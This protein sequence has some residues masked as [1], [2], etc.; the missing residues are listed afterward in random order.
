MLRVFLSVCFFM[1]FTL[2]A[3]AQDESECIPYLDGQYRNMESGASQCGLSA[4]DMATFP[5]QNDDEYD[6][7]GGLDVSSQLEAFQACA[8][9]YTCAARF[10]ECAIKNKKSG[11][12]CRQAMNSCTSANPIPK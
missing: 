6:C 4:S 11:M 12:G 7:G 5:G 9:V 8:R 2:T 3:V 1:N 10:Y